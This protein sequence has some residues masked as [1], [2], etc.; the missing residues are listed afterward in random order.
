VAALNRV[1]RAKQDSARWVLGLYADMVSVT[2]EPRGR[3]EQYADRLEKYVEYELAEKEVAELEWHAAACVGCATTLE[4]LFEAKVRPAPEPKPE[5]TA[6]FRGLMTAM[7]Q[8]IAR[9]GRLQVTFCAASLIVIVIGLSFAPRLARSSNEPS[10]QARAAAAMPE[11]PGETTASRVSGF[12]P[13]RP[14]PEFIRIAALRPGVR[15]SRAL[16]SPDAGQGGAIGSWA[17]LEQLLGSLREFPVPPTAPPS[18]PPSADVLGV[19]RFAP[20]ETDV[21]V[22]FVGASGHKV[23][24][25]SRSV[26]VTD[27]TATDTA[28]SRYVNNLDLALERVAS[29]GVGLRRARLVMEPSEAV[30]WGSLGYYET[31]KPLQTDAG[32]ITTLEMCE[33][34]EPQR[35]LHDL[36]ETTGPEPVCDEAERPTARRW[37]LAQSGK[38]NLA[39]QIQIVNA[40]M[41]SST[42][43]MVVL[44]RQ[45]PAVVHR[46]YKIGGYKRLALNM[47]DIL[48]KWAGKSYGT[49]LDVVAGSPV[50]VEG[51]LVPIVATAWR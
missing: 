25:Y 40:T 51:S 10:L 28:V 48:P 26:D 13:A 22:E 2:G 34:A 45:E 35:P 3:C 27:A 1:T 43:K 15:S 36:I 39:L 44:N 6:I 11:S 30:A 29:A 18:Q 21:H 19:V 14:L 37:V 12:L 47:D 46:T 31:A 49:V 5:R 20:L 42:V 9:P 24:S 50:T 33:R 17:S 23:A 38:A 8:C 41:T 32:R 4:E 7:S 16:P